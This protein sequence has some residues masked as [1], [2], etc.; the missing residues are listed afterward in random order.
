V[1]NPL[2]A[3]LCIRRVGGRAGDLFTRDIQNKNKQSHYFLH[4]TNIDIEHFAQWYNSQ[5]Q[6]GV[7]KHDNTVGIR[8]ISKQELNEVMN[9][10]TPNV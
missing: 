10:Y 3:T 9:K 4:T 1:S 8:S 5:L 7:F 2:D 6:V